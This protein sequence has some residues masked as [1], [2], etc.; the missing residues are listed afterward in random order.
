MAEVA[1]PVDDAVHGGGLLQDHRTFVAWREEDAEEECDVLHGYVG[2]VV[3]A[4]FVV[5]GNMAEGE[6]SFDAFEGRSA[7]I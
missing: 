6:E 2:V 5:G 4:V 7:A 3:A 1:D